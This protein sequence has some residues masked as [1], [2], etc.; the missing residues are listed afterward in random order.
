MFA[1]RNADTETC[2]MRGMLATFNVRRE[3]NEALGATNTR[4]YAL[5]SPE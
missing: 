4:R 2:W 5:N 1:R 3:G